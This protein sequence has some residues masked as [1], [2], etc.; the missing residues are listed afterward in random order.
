MKWIKL[1]IKAMGSVSNVY[2]I[3]CDEFIVKTRQTTGCLRTLGNDLKCLTRV[4]WNSRALHM[5]VSELNWLSVTSHTISLHCVRW[6]RNKDKHLHSHSMHLFVLSVAKRLL[7]TDTLNLLIYREM[8]A[9]F[10]QMDRFYNAEQI[11]SSWRQR[12]YGQ[13]FLFILLRNTKNV[14]RYIL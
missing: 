12:N 14:D 13:H 9:R 1:P 7:F 11:L 2:F 10:C 5:F 8:R 6:E 3:K 4:Q